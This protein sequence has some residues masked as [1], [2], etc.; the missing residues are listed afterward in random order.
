MI[1]GD[2]PWKDRKLTSLIQLHVL[3]SQWEGVPLIPADILIPD[4][5]KDFLQLCFMKDPTQRPMADKL[6]EHVFLAVELDESLGDSGTMDSLPIRSQLAKVAASISFARDDTVGEIDAQ[7]YSRQRYQQGRGADAAWTEA[8]KSVSAMESSNPYARRDKSK[9]VEYSRPRQGSTDSAWVEVE[10]SVP[11]METSNPY[12]RKNKSKPVLFP[13][14]GSPMTDRERTTSD[15]QYSPSKVAVP[16]NKPRS[17]SLGETHD[18]DNQITPTDS[19]R[20]VAQAV[21]LSTRRP[22]LLV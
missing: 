3:L 13:D 4:D 7:I 8:E 10:P 9:P 16:I 22:M 17:T 21:G 11:I 19:A 2:P 1:T 20:N 14:L 12:A 15:H 5:L 18:Y 6:L